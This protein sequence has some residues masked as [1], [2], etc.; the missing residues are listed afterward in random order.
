MGYFL[1]GLNSSE[2]QEKRTWRSK[3]RRNHRDSLQTDTLASSLFLPRRRSGT[4]RPYLCHFEELRQFGHPVEESLVDLQSFFALVLLHVKVFLCISEG[5]NQH[6]SFTK[7]SFNPL[8]D[9]DDEYAQKKFAEKVGF[10][11]YLET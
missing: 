4:N 5:Q 8:M 11:F 9:A 6:N 7:V 10:F 3:E 2:K 1:K